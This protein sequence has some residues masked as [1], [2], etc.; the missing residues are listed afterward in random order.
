[1]NFARSTPITGIHRVVGET[2]AL[3]RPHMYTGRDTKRRHGQCADEQSTNHSEGHEHRLDIR[4]PCGPP[5]A[6][7]VQ[8]T[9]RSEPAACEGPFPFAGLE[10]K[11]GPIADTRARSRGESQPEG[12]MIRRSRTSRRPR[13]PPPFFPPALFFGGGG[14][15]NAALLVAGVDEQSPQPI[16]GRV[17]LGDR[18]DASLLLRNHGLERSQRIHE[19]GLRVAGVDGVPLQRIVV[20]AASV[21]DGAPNETK[22]VRYVLESDRP[23]LDGRMAPRRCGPQNLHLVDCVRP[24]GNEPPRFG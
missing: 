5:Q 12:K 8:I 13:V 23:H 22:D 14:A 17:E 10:S 9:P 15:S 18:D 20:V 21:F 4:L 2:L 6:T 1:M 16:V 24:G 11:R 3:I 7:V 19:Q